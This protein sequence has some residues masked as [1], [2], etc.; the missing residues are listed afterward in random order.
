MP[1]TTTN[2]G[3]PARAENRPEAW[4]PMPD[5]EGF[6]EVSNDGRIKR[7]A[8][9]ASNA[10][11]GRILEAHRDRKGYL[12]VNLSRPGVRVSR[13]VHRLVGRAWLGEPP[14]GRDCVDHRNSARDD[15][16]AENLHWVSSAENRRLTIARGRAVYARGSRHG[17][18]KLAEADVRALRDLAGVVSQR[19]LGKR[20]G[21]SQ[22]VVGSAQRRATWA[23]IL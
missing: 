6:Y 18:A 1:N 19:E 14:E 16:R 22:T 7:V 23:H 4:K 15:N 17:S 11:P 8:G 10:I 3:D 2:D 21:V 12:S 20:F 13:L 9:G 5:W